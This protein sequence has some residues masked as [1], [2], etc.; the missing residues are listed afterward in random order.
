MAEHGVG[1]AHD[2][3]TANVGVEGEITLISSQWW[4]KRIHHLLAEPGWEDSRCC[5]HS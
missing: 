1:G 4:L 2:R 5:E 3:R